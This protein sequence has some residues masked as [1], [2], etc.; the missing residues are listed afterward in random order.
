[1]LA[2]T[3]LVVAGHSGPTASP[4]SVG[5]LDTMSS[6][7]RVAATDT[8]LRLRV[9]TYN[10]LG[11]LR[12]EPG[13]DLAYRVPAD[14]R[15]QLGADVLRQQSPDV[16]GMQELRPNQI[17]DFRREFPGYVLW[18]DYGP[19]NIGRPTGIMWND[20]RFAKVGSGSVDVPSMGITR[21]MTW[22]QLQDRSTGRQFAYFN[23]HNS[24]GARQSERDEDLRREVAV[25]AQLRASGVPVLFAGDT[26][27]HEQALCTVITQTDLV[28]ASG[29]SVVDGVCKPPARIRIDQIF[30]NATF[31]DYVVIQP[32]LV[33]RAT[34][35]AIVAATATLN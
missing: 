34:D 14:L 16:V 19:G 6:T 23:V 2:A 3:G 27:E 33:Q 8:P 25:I 20:A 31:S 22:V 15:A 17:A 29:G 28:A 1:M 24:P 13:G 4:E 9:V 11:S 21:R 18:S 32:P 12:T 10:T 35:H 30:G 26:N 7:A 5:P